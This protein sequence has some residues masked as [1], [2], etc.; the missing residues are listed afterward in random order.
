MRDKTSNPVMI[1]ERLAWMSIG[2]AVFFWI[3]ESAIHVFIF[4]EPGFIQQISSPPSHEVW[5]RIVVVA[6]FI[7]FGMYAQ[8]SIIQ[9][10]RAEEAARGAH[11]ELNQIFETAADGMRV[12]DKDFNV[13]RV[14]RTFSRL[15]GVRK[16]EAIGKK[17]YEV[18]RGDV[19]HTSGCPVTRILGG[20]E[21]VEYDAQKERNDGSTV[22][23]IVTATPFRGAGGELIGIVED[24]KDIAERKQAEK[25]LQESEEKYSTLVENSLT[26][27]FIH[28]DGRYV[29]VNDRFADIH[30][31]QPGEL[32]G[33]DPLTLVHPDEREALRQVMSKR[34]EG[35]K[36]PERYEVR[37][38][39]KDGK[40]IWCEM[41]ATRI[42]YGGRPAIMGN[43]VDITERRRAEQALFRA[44][45]DWENT[46]DAMT[47]LVML[48]DNE[49]QI[50]RVNKAAAEALNTTK[51]GLVGSKCYE[52]IHGR[53]RPIPG[54]PLA[55]TKKA[56]EAHTTEMT[57]PSLGGAFLCS[58]FPI[59]DREGRLTSYV[60]TLKNVTGSKQLEAQLQHAQRMEAI[61][62]LAGG[63]AHDFNNVLMGIQGHT[64]LMLLHTESDHPHFGHIA[65]IEDMVHR[66]ADL[67]RQLLGFARGGKYEVKPTDVNE[68][69]E[70]S[71]EMFSRTKKEIQIHKKYEQA[72]WPVEVDQAQI[73]QVLLN[74]YVNAWQAMLHGGDLSIKTSNVVLDEKYTMPF[75]V[76][77]GTYVKISVTDTGIGMDKATQQRIFDPFFTT[78]EMARGTGLGLSS[79]YGIIKS[80][81]GIIN[82]Y[83][84]K[85]KG[86]TFNIY[87]PASRNEVTSK[88][89]RFAEEM[90]KGRET[91]LLVDDEK[92]ILD[93]GEEM[94]EAMGYSVLVARSGKEAV[95]VY[96]NHKDEIDLVILDMIMPGIGGSETYDRIKEEN[97]KVKAL[98]SSGYSIDGQATEILEKGCDGFIQK[99]FTMIKLSGK[100][101]EVLEKG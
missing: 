35:E 16:N 58:T 70:K 81:G 76:K 5:M 61:G 11:A 67:T 12:V 97:P 39:R 95:E 93:V 31:Y 80:H 32:I 47:D 92:E 36:A 2:L 65:G 54:C 27:I 48:L 86:S 68:L 52:A 84:E 26:G 10:R 99:P 74:L 60:H 46:F 88:E 15:S 53:S 28:Q 50:I 37:R 69:I 94:L 66:G 56:S 72:I 22:P 42:E 1:T 100:I 6:M 41:M 29:F 33:K 77:A 9:R 57:E 30:G 98:L 4:Q 63:I 8:L 38:L 20:E 90:V 23:C 82:V 85:G 91:I 59:L 45:E 19:C 21:R 96:E 34:L 44:K 3:V 24:F 25:A 62:T 73:E 79:A 71:C 7:G 51:E 43:I 49:H 83:S 89:E 78:K 101:R 14:N 55:L 13:L 64:S 40:T 17:C 87:L 18:F 75:G